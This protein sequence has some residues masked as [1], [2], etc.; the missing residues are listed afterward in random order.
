MRAGLRLSLTLHACLFILKSSFIASYF[1]MRA[2]R[3]ASTSGYFQ[4]GRSVTRSLGQYPRHRMVSA[5]KWLFIRG[6]RERVQTSWKFDL[7][8]ELPL[9]LLPPSQ[10]SKKEIQGPDCSVRIFEKSCTYLLCAEAGKLRLQA[11]ILQAANSL[12]SSCHCAKTY[13]CSCF[14]VKATLHLTW[15]KITSMV[16][17]RAANDQN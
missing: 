9:L 13:V 10:K 3:A 17:Q 16:H 12:W 14:E 11:N 7:R 5:G 6:M 8:P 15:T 1:C 2:H 4:G